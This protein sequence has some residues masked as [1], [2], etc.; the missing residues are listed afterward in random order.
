MARTTPQLVQKV[1]LND[2][3]VEGAPDLGPAIDSASVLVEDLRLFGLR[4]DLVVDETRLEI[5]ERWLAAHFY[6]VSDRPFANRSTGGAG[7]GF[8]G[9]TGQGLDFTGYGQ[10]AKVLDPTGFL[11]S[12]GSGGSEGAV[13]PKVGGF[14]A[15]TS[16]R[17]GD[18]NAP[19]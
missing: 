1:L 16:T 13:R 3:D 10:H 17:D 7:A 14:W 9:K 15:G 5:V 12:L 6:A 11:S 2:Y 8:D 19:T 18:A 4:R